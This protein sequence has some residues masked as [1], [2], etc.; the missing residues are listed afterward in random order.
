MRGNVEE[1]AVNVR[2]KTKGKKRE[3]TTP[4]EEMGSKRELHT[5]VEE[6]TEERVKRPRKMGDRR[7]KE[8]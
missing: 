6:R 3:N 8:G 2:E 4:G 7:R 5:H 1:N